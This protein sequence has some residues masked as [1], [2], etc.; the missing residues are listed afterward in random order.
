M[1]KDVATTSGFLANLPEDVRKALALVGATE[2][3]QVH[4]IEEMT[5]GWQLLKKDAKERLVGVNCYVVKMAFNDSDYG[6]VAGE[7]TR[8]FVVLH[9]LTADMSGR[10]VVVDGGTGLYEQ[11][12]AWC[13]AN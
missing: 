2:I 8:K 3:D 6:K 5:G 9:I 11:S 1:A 12:L 10:Y 4:D 13:E 7:A